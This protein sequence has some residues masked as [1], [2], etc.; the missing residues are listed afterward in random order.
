L[1]TEEVEGLQDGR[2]VGVLLLVSELDVRGC[3]SSCGAPVRL[4]F[5]SCDTNGTQMLFPN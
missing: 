2:G 4:L 3:V 5:A 1:S